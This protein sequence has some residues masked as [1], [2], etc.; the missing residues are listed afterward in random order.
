MP[1]NLPTR[2]SG[3]FQPAAIAGTFML[4]AALAY[5]YLNFEKLQAAAFPVTPSAQVQSGRAVTT[6][7]L[8]FPLC[9]APPHFNC[10]IDGDTF[11]LNGDSIRIADIDAPETRSARCTYEAQLGDR[12]TKRLRELLSA[13]PFEIRRY[14]RD[15]DRYGRK[16]RI[17]AQNGQSIGGI[18]VSEGLARPWGGKREPWC[19]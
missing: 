11:Y 19:G 4:G 8:H 5:G 9:G 14:E 18:L 3:L 7:T 10:V 17:I 6:T 2:K 13:K 1:I 15:V 12:A 16:L